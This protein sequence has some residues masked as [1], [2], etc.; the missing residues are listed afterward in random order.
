V[1][2]RYAWN[3]N[4]VVR[5][6][7]ARIIMIMKLVS[8]WYVMLWHVILWYVMLWYVML[9]YVMLWNIMLRYVM[10]RN[11][12]ARNA[13]VRNDVA[14]TTV[15]RNAGVRYIVVHAVVRCY[16]SPHFN[17]V[18][19]YLLRYHYDIALLWHHNY[20][21]MVRMRAWSRSPRHSETPTGV[22]NAAIQYCSTRNAAM[23]CPQHCVF[24]AP[25]Q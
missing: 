22:R 11:A 3:R 2:L 7:V 21:F 13:E 24:Q 12:V 15:V 14:R 18:P 17:S 4:A 19:Q 16:G 1:A 5:N 10:L 25:N 8:V 20:D 9:R 6:A 23:L